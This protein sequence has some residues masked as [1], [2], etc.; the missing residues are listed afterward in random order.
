MIDSCGTVQSKPVANLLKY[1]VV[2]IWI[3]S[4]LNKIKTANKNLILRVLMS[5]IVVFFY[6]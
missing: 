3:N 1:D 5:E 2:I 6:F 4:N